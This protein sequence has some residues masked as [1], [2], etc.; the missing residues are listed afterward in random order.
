M[1]VIL[2]NARVQKRKI[3]WYGNIKPTKIFY[4]VGVFTLH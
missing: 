3:K 1:V 2:Y 4:L